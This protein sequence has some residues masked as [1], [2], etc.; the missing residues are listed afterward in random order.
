[1]ALKA[2]RCHGRKERHPVPFPIRSS[3]MVKMTLLVVVG[4]GAVLTLILG[5][6]G[7]YS[8]NIILSD[9]KTAAQDKA[10]SVA[11]RM[12]QELGAVVKIAQSLG[13]ALEFGQW[14]EASAL[15]LIR[16]IVG[17][18]KEIFGSTIAFEPYAFKSD[19]R[20]FAP[21]FCRGQSGLRYVQL[22]DNSYDYFTRDW[23]S[24][25]REMKRASWSA[26]YFDEGG[27]NALMTT[28]SCPF[29]HP[30]TAGKPRKLR[31]IITVDVSLDRL[32]EMASAVRIAETGYA[33][34]ISENGTFLAHPDRRL[35][36]R[37]SLFS[38]AEEKRDPSLRTI[39]RKMIG[40]NKG[41]ED[42][43]E[44]LTGSDSYLAFARLPNTGWALGVVFPKRE[45]FS[46]V[47]Q[48]HRTITILAAVGVTLLL[49]VSFFSA[50]S[51]TGPLRLMAHATRKIAEGD[52]NVDLSHIGRQDEVGQLAQAFTHMT[53]DLRKYIKD[54]TETTAA[55][56]RIESELSIA[57]TIQRSMLP[58]KFPAFPE[59]DEFDIFAL[60]RPAKEVG[61]D[62]YDFFLVDEDHLCVAVGD[63]SGKGVPAALFMA[64]TKYLIEAAVSAGEPPDLALH[65]VNGHLAK[66]NDSC[67]FVTIFLGIL[68]LRTGEFLYANGG[69]NPPVLAERAYEAAFLGS[70]GGP[71]VGIMED[72]EF[73]M[74]R[75]VLGRGALLLVYSDGV[76][77]A[78]DA[79]ETAFAEER[80]RDTVTRYREDSARNISTGLLE[81]I[82]TFCTG[83]PQADDIT[84]LT[85]RV[86]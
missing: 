74:D 69:H 14:E 55:K 4:T 47:T 82:D 71:V 83:A 29:F 20:A 13:V 73:R 3:I 38:L 54:L 27:G 77:E 21:Y 48:L 39:G 22:G 43:R 5:F 57:A 6:S 68:D 2:G 53:D 79:K 16:Q 76:T 9:A 30:E 18:N 28:Y 44:A 37:E 32:T 50:R 41:F 19:T 70:P 31:G 67:M 10:L 26:P 84:I 23:Y 81:A 62:F 63:V 46:E 8:R 36:M 72:A 17:E 78:F 25:P 64:V 75:L 7:I 33:F 80:L 60:M 58:S 11:R 65:T 40:E 49:T 56:Q 86:K 15:N 52:L 1:M 61:G 66:N 42:A 85:L 24:I 12:D 34:L 45:L 51:L 59:R 35:V